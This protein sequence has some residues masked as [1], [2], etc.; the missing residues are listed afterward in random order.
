[1]QFPTVDFHQD[2]GT[3]HGQQQG[4]PHDQAAA[5]AH[6]HQQRTNHDHD[7]GAQVEQEALH[8]LLDLVGLVVQ[9]FHGDTGGAELA[10]LQQSLLQALPHLDH[11]DTGRER[12]A[13][14]DGGLTIHAEQVRGNLLVT[15]VNGSDIR[16]ANQLAAV[17]AVDDGIDLHL[18][19]AQS[20]VHH[21]AIDGDPTGIEHRVLL[22]EEAGHAVKIQVQGGEFLLR[23]FYK[24]LLLL[25]AEQG[26]LANPLDQLQF[27]L[28]TIDILLQLAGLVIVA[29][30]HQ[31]NTVHVPVVVIDPGHRGALGQLWRHIGDLA[32]QLVPGLLDFLRRHLL[33]HFHQYLGQAGPGGGANGVDLRQLANGVFQRVGQL[34]LHLLGCGTGVGGDDHCVL[35]NKGRVFQAPQVE[36]R[37]GTAHR[38]QDKH[39]PADG[40]MAHRVF[41]DIHHAL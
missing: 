34:Q 10:Q 5:P 39:H 13:H 4:R 12:D 21:L 26:D 31:G 11:V 29:G 3:Q 19:A 18:Q 28:E 24:Y 7:R 38:D 22:V 30:D 23:D 6:G 9:V 40:A 37:H 8:R 33:V 20:Q 17:A 36:K 2:E 1:M 15:A 14:G 16:Q 41:S 25:F 27:A 35:A 32:A